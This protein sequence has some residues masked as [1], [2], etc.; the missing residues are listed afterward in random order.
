MRHN[1]LY[2]QEGGG[3]LTLP[4]SEDEEGELSS[5]AWVKLGRGGGQGTGK[6]GVRN[7]GDEVGRG[8]TETG[9]KHT[10]ICTGNEPHAY[11]P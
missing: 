8:E 6:E 5:R 10:L 2:N 1:T 4:G 7:L 11:S 9:N 3:T